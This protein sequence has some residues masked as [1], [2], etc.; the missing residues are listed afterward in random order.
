[1]TIFLILSGTASAVP[2]NEINNLGD[3][4]NIGNTTY[5]SSFTMNANYILIKDISI[6]DEIWDS[7]GTS[8]NPF[9]GFF[10]GNG[11]TITF[12]GDTVFNSE[13]ESYGLF[14]KVSD[15]AKLE[16]ISLV[17][18]GNLTNGNQDTF[19]ILAGHCIGS[20]QIYISNCSLN[21]KTDFF[22]KGNSNVGGLIGS[23]NKGSAVSIENCSVDGNIFGYIAV[24][25]LVGRFGNGTVKNC[26]SNCEIKTTG[27]GVGGLIG[28]ISP[29]NGIIL[30]QNS[31]AFGSVTSNK[32]VA[33]GL[34]GVLNNTSG[35]TTI[36][37]CYASVT[38]KS[39]ANNGA[40]GGLIGEL[41]AGSVT[42]CYA[43][44]DVITNSGNSGGLIGLI[45][46]NDSNTMTVTNCYA[47]GGDVIGHPAATGGLVG[48]KSNKE[49]D[50]NATGSF[51]LGTKNTFGTQ[52]TSE[53]MKQI[54]T[55][56]NWNITD[57]PT[58]D[59]VWYIREGCDYPRLSWQYGVRTLDDLKNIGNESYKSGWAMYAPYVLMAD[60]SIDDGEWISIGNFDNPFTGTF[61]GNGKTIT[62]TKDTEFSK[63]DSISDPESDGY[64]LFGFGEAC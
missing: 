53:A 10:N 20:E 35:S 14:A 6:D 29:S 55:F 3:L 26:I 56:E 33:G 44:G 23:I 34:I 21:I 17:A 59:S 7:I 9:K 42:N 39:E 18:N 22:M 32:L 1:M 41:W 11:K 43:I 37:N 48:S 24:G 52:I 13:S 15:N 5:N 40:S 8:D 36:E 2:V 46:N 57:E 62:F 64:G 12:N 28:I 45:A 19:G 38:T 27:S 51:Y 16:N 4:K 30:V 60:I 49:A 63:T 25:G 50:W 54:S 31:S 47:I 61:D 58:A